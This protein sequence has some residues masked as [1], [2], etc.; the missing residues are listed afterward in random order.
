[1]MAAHHAGAQPA[2]E[3]KEKKAKQAA[4]DAKRTPEEKLA[5]GFKACKEA[6]NKLPKRLL[7]IVD[8]ETGKLTDMYTVL[9]GHEKE[10][11]KLVMDEFIEQLDI[12][13]RRRGLLDDPL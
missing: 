12:E 6:G 5:D 8:R 10:V 4:A 11:S 9:E 7:G 1:M 3:A 2:K 13:L